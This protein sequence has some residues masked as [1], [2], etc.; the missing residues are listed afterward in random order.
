MNRSSCVASH[1]SSGPRQS[2]PAVLIPC[3]WCECH[4]R[5]K[6][7]NAVPTTT[8][9]TWQLCAEAAGPRMVQGHH[10]AV[11]AAGELRGR[12]SS[13]A[14]AARAGAWR[15]AEAAG[16]QR[17]PLCA[18]QLHGLSFSRFLAGNAAAP[19]LASAI[20]AHQP[21][22][23]G[24]NVRAFNLGTSAGDGSC[25]V[26]AAY[27]PDMKTLSC[28]CPTCDRPCGCASC[29]GPCRDA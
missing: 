7:S 11:S 22:S 2:E 26:D 5:C 4:A 6:R 3:K 10:A 17:P 23:S 14:A 13:A 12:N 29:G 8:A 21:C 1:R 19:K 25:R 24:A 28:R 15:P 20:G 27:A 9:R 16:G 18:R